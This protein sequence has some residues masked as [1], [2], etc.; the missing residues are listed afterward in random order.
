MSNNWIF[1]NI[2]V[3]DPTQLELTLAT[4]TLTMTVTPQRDICVLTKYGGAP[5]TP[6]ELLSHIDV[7]LKRAVELNAQIDKALT[8]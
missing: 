3:L 6:E 2:V 1:R 4:S 5:L 7:G 8:K